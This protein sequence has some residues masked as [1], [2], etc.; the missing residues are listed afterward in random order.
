MPK[1]ACSASRAAAA[2][3]IGTSSV[4][5]FSR[6]RSRSLRSSAGVKVV[7]QSR[8]TKAGDLY[9]VKVKSIK[10]IVRF[11]FTDQRP[12]TF[13]EAIQPTEYGFWANV[14]CGR[15]FSQRSRRRTCPSSAC[16]ALPR[17]TRW[18][19]AGA[20]R[21]QHDVT[22]GSTPSAV[23]DVCLHAGRRLGCPGSPHITPD[24]LSWPLDARPR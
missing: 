18:S 7:V 21:A 17:P 24:W 12:V 22:G 23:V 14:N 11:T 20:R 8:L 5:A 2:T 15:Q 19:L 13:W 10:A 4:R 16:L 6:L 9:L 1:C 3:G